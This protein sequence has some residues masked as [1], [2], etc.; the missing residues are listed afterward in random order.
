M[1]D[2]E[3]IGHVPTPGAGDSDS[4]RNGVTTGRAFS[5]DDLAFINRMTTTGQVLPS[6][7]HELNNSLQIIAGM[8][9]ILGLRGQLPDDAADK[10]QK[11]GAQAG[12][13]AGMLRD[14]VSFARRD[15]LLRKIDLHAAVERATTLR[16]YHLSR[17]RVTVQVTARQDGPLVAKA[18]SQAVVQV[19]VNLILNAEEAL[20]GQDSREIR[21]ELWRAD[22][23]VHCA[24]S[25]SGAGFSGDGMA[26]A[27]TPFFTTK[28]GGAA[29]LGLAVARQLV[30][31]DGGR[32]EVAGPV[33]A[34]VAV[35][36]PASEGY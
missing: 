3:D 22:G 31:Q 13:A 2:S 18:D 1:S 5:A 25:D 34:R 10:V 8:V 14:L 30:E 6:V 33:P 28:T 20:A 16:R 9:E 36:W 26:H 7:A 27:S 15:S 12:K 29:G 32:L 24:V 4:A 21:V 11:I 19:L 17:G 23:F 35:A